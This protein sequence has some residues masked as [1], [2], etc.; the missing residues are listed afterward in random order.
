MKY[1]KRFMVNYKKVQYNYFNIY[2]IIIS[3]V[4]FFYFKLQ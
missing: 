3:V 1:G 4:K 2:H